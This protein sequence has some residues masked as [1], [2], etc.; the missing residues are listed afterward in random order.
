LS[1]CSSKKNFSLCE[2]K[3]LPLDYLPSTIN[4][5]E[6]HSNDPKHSD[7]FL[8]KCAKH[9]NTELTHKV[10]VLY[11]TQSKIIFGFFSLHMNRLPAKVKKDSLKLPFLDVAF[12]SITKKYLKRTKTL[13][14]IL[15]MI[16]E[17]I[18]AIAMDSSS[19]IGCRFIR[20]YISFNKEKKEDPYEAINR[21]SLTP[22]LHEMLDKHKYFAINDS[23]DP[24]IWLKQA[25]SE[26]KEKSLVFKYYIRNLKIEKKD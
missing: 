19:K 25:I 13:K 14:R 18:D 16:L 3:I 24:V 10:Y 8:K 11:S 7:N 6:Y 2:D 22:H 1:S 5:N 23:K 4:L 9:Q 21:E 12:L 20:T 17:K 26:K 15:K